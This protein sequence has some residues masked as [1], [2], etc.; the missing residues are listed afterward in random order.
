MGLCMFCV[1][2]TPPLRLYRSIP[3]TFHLAWKGQCSP[4]RKNKQTKITF[5]L[6]PWEG[7]MHGWRLPWAS[8]ISSVNLTGSQPKFLF[9]AKLVEYLVKH[10]IFWLDM[11]L[12]TQ[13]TCHISL[14]L[15]PPLEFDFDFDIDLLH[16]VFSILSRGYFCAVSSGSVASRTP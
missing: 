1:I 9:Q 12:N 8:L 11:H 15:S 13:G 5:T 16:L 6:V 10:S 3:N 7:I 14:F 2:L 4:W